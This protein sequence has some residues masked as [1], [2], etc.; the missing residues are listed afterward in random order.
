AKLTFDKVS[1]K[2]ATSCT[3]ELAKIEVDVVKSQDPVTKKDVFVAPDGYDATKDDDLH[4]CE[5]NKPSVGTLEVKKSSGNTYS[6]SIS[7]VGGTHA[8]KE[9]EVK[10]GGTVIA[11]LPASAS[12]TYSTSH[13]FTD[14]STQTVTATVIDSAYYSGAKSQ[15][16]TP[17]GSGSGND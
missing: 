15:S 8:L 17:G 13:T 16:V 12:G 5:D 4:K 2:K 11:T 3:P 9:I 14:N 6:I 1:K 7:V 10:V